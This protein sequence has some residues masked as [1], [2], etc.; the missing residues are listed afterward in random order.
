MASLLM[1][2]SMGFHHS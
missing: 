2:H 1:T